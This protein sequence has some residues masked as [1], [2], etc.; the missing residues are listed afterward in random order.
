MST[1]I[2]WCDETVNIVAGC[3]KVSPGCEHCYAERM[4]TRLA[5]NPA[6]Q[7]EVREAYRIAIF[8]AV[9]L[10]DVACSWSGRVVPIPG[11]VERLAAK[12]A[13]W[14]KPRR[15]FV[16]S[17]G[18]LFHDQVPFDLVDQVCEVISTNPRHTFMF[19][20]KRPE[21]M[22]LYMEGC[23]RGADDIGGEFPW[24][25]LWLGVTAENQQQAD[26][27][28]PIL[29]DTPAAV[30]FVSVEPMLGQVRL[31]HMDADAA[32]H[33]SLCQINALTGK[34]TD[35]G[36]P[37]QDVPHLDW[38]I[39]GGETGPGARKMSPQWAKA[40]RDQCKEAGVPFFFKNLGSHVDYGNGW[41]TTGRH[42]TPEDLNVRQFPQEGR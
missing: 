36:R 13:R 16:Q 26:A 23:Q 4:T 19:L 5:F 17:M 35:M 7:S 18:D 8:K 3:T 25:N 32:G 15:I 10:P 40:L 12:C 24:R 37:C 9:N 38:V 28:I 22:R 34:H 33:K 39:C 20:T 1:K 11:A 14:R 6:I 2:E 41:S 31:D 30:R 42:A 21:Q 27:R 29:L